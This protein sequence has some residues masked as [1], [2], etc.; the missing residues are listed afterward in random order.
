M[1][2]NQILQESHFTRIAYVR[3]DEYAS[4]NSHAEIFSQYMRDLGMQLVADTVELG[5]VV[6]IGVG[7][8]ELE[9]VRS[10]EFIG[11]GMFELI[12]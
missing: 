6:H 2:N 11:F 12:E 8:G 7:Y 3:V 5:A 9:S 4:T 1:T 10:T